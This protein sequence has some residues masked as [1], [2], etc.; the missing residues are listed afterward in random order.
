MDLFFI[1]FLNE[2]SPASFFFTILQQINA[3]NA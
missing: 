2:P 3:K 1:Y